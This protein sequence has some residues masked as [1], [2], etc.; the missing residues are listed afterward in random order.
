MIDNMFFIDKNN[1]WENLAEG[2]RRKIVGYDQ[3][4]MLI[5]VKFST[6]STVP[7]HQHP[8]VQCSV[9][10]SGKFEVIIGNAAM[11]LGKGDGFF[12]PS[13]IEHKVNCLLEGIII[14]S[15]N[16]AREDFIK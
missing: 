7:F 2:V 16:P 12:V 14:D 11:I 10:E 6:A 5:R 9:I 4:L 13:G 15:F 3:N 1:N 8:H